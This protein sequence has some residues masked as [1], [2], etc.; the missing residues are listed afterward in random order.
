MHIFYSLYFNQWNLKR[1]SVKIHLNTSFNFIFFPWLLQTGLWILYD[2]K[3]KVVDFHFLVFYCMVSWFIIYLIV[4]DRQKKNLEIGSLLCSLEFSKECS[5]S[6]QS[7]ILVEVTAQTLEY[8]IYTLETI[9]P[10]VKVQIFHIIFG[11]FAIL[12]NME[13]VE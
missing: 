9:F 2:L 6:F 3:V 13:A 10:K 7:L 12:N 8:K 4:Y 11:M 5:I 1:K